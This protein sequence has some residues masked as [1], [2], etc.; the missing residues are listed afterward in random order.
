MTEVSG[1]WGGG[2]GQAGCFKME[3]RTAVDGLTDVRIDGALTNPRL[4]RY[5]LIN[6]KCFSKRSLEEFRFF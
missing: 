2:G 3:E 1:F 4:I 6:G 5:K